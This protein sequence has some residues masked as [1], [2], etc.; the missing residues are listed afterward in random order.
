MR[1]AAPRSRASSSQLA[2]A[3]ATALPRRADD[4]N[5]LPDAIDSDCDDGPRWTKRVALARSPFLAPRARRDRA[6]ARPGGGEASPAAA[7]T[8]AAAVAAAAVTSSVDLR[9]DLLAVPAHHRR[10]AVGLPLARARHRLRR[11]QRVPAAPE[12]GLGQRPAGRARTPAIDASTT[13]A[14]S[15]PTSRRSCSRTSRSGCS[16]RRTARARRRRA[17]RP[18]RPYVGEAART[19]ARA[20]AS[21]SASPSSRSSS[22]RC[23]SS[24]SRSP[25]ADAEGRRRADPRRVRGE[26]RDRRSTPT[27]PSRRWLFA[28]RRRR[29]AASRPAR[30]RTFP[31]PNCGAPWQARATGTQLRVV[32]PGRRQRPVRLGRRADRARLGRRAPAD[33]DRPRSPSAAPICR[34][35]ASPTS[36]RAGRSSTR[37]DPALTERGARR[38]RSR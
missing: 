36:T 14:G 26:R 19:A 11:R 9:A 15:I 38:A 23:A 18:S 13:S 25:I 17:R 5:E 22:A 20:R 3:L 24:A 31:C 29:Q 34:R 28:P 35:I 21:R 12:Q 4:I 2:P 30:A 33:A 1:A 7:V 8:A 32:R 37:D 16:R 6:C 10:T 27:T